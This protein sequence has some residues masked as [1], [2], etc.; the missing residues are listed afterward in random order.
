MKRNQLSNM[1][2]YI[3]SVGEVVILAIIMGIM[4]GVKVNESAARTNWGLSVLI[5]FSTGV[6]LLLLLAG[7]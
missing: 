7:R 4:L 1:S 6:W 3:A 5:A 2:F